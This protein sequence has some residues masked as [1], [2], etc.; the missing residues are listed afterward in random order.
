MTASIDLQKFC[1]GGDDQRTHLRQPWRAPVGIVA[2]DGAVLIV[3]RETTGDVPEYRP[4]THP[5]V[6]KM[7][8]DN[9]ASSPW[10]ALDSIE[11]PPKTVCGRCN[12]GGT[13]WVR[14]CDECDGGEFEHGSHTYTCRNCSGFGARRLSQPFDGAHPETCRGCRGDG[15][16]I[17]PV[18]LPGGTCFQRRYLALLAELPGCEIAPSG[19]QAA[20]FR[21]DGGEGLLMPCWS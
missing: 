20:R 19:R 13:L 12:G 4:G 16:A 3:V 17:Q 5:N 21:F 14:E 9:P 2:T 18:E 15:A 6:S 11:L 10:I 8:N 1:A 7:L